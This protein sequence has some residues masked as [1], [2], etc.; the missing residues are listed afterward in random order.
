M[1]R[2]LAMICIISTL[3]FSLTACGNSTDATTPATN[4]TEEASTEEVAT[5]EE[6]VA[7]ITSTE[8]S[9]PEPVEKQTPEPT[10]E[11]TEEFT[12]DIAEAKVADLFNAR[13]ELFANGK[14]DTDLNFLVA[15]ETLSGGTELTGIATSDA[16]NTDEKAEVKWATVANYFYD[17]INNNS[18]YYDLGEYLTSHT[19]D[20]I[21]DR[22][23]SKLRNESVDTDN[24]VMLEAPGVLP[25]LLENLDNLSF[26]DLISGEECTAAPVSDVDVYY[27]MPILINGEKCGVTAVFD[28]AGNLL[29]L[30]TVDEDG[31]TDDNYRDSTDEVLALEN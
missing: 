13:N 1:K 28:E 2:K 22:Y 23:F 10:E 14:V 11:P 19:Y 27:E 5:T 26:G 16:I 8:K 31:W 21:I 24:V 30:I 18:G 25:Y 17:Y 15:A 29:N 20:E 7:N 12:K 9:T 4:E 6:S 3:A